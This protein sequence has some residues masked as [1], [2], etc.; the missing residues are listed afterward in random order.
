[1]KIRFTNGDTLL[2]LFG[3]GAPASGAT[4]PIVPIP[5]YKEL[6][7]PLASCR[8]LLSVITQI[9]VSNDPYSSVRLN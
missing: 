7:Q 6:I 8:T 9:L 3:K 5:A 2:R 4:Q 1:M